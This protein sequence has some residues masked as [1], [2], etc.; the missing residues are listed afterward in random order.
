MVLF[1]ETLAHE[2]VTAL[3]NGLYELALEE[4]GYASQVLLHW[5]IDAQVEEEAHASEILETLKMAGGEG[6]ALVMMDRALASR[7]E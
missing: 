2:K 3:I 7:G 1:E 6:Q 4:K 5:Y